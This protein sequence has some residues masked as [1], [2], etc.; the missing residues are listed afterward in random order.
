M[1]RAKAKPIKSLGVMG[2][3]STH[4]TQLRNDVEAQITQQLPQLR[5]RHLLQ[6]R[7]RHVVDEVNLARHLEV[8]Q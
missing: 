5:L 8:R 2:L 6:R 4:P 3:R 7:A 1:G